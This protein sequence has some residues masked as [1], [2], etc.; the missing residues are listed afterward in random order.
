MRR[1]FLNGPQL[2]PELES[3]NS[4]SPQSA[5]AP[6]KAHIL[7][8][9][10]ASFKLDRGLKSENFPDSSNKPASGLIPAMLPLVV[11]QLDLKDP[12]DITTLLAIQR[13]S[14]YGWSTVT[15]I[16]YR[17]VEVRDWQKFLCLPD[18][19]QPFTEHPLLFKHESIGRL[20]SAQIRSFKRRYDAFS[21][22]KT[23]VL[24]T[25]P[26]FPQTL[27]FFKGG[28]WRQADK[29]TI[30]FSEDHLMMPNLVEMDV[31][32]TAWIPFNILAGY[33]NAEEMMHKVQAERP[34]LDLSMPRLP[35]LGAIA[36]PKILHITA[37]A[38]STL[39][40]GTATAEPSRLLLEGQFSSFIGSHDRSQIH[41]HDMTPRLLMASSVNRCDPASVHV[42]M[43]TRPFTPPNQ[44]ENALEFV[45]IF[46]NLLLGRLSVWAQATA[47]IFQ[48]LGQHRKQPKESLK[49]Q[50]RITGGDNGLVYE[51]KN[52][53]QIIQL[54]IKRLCRQLVM[55]GLEY[56]IVRLADL[57]E[58]VAKSYEGVV[59]KYVGKRV[60]IGQMLFDPP[61]KSE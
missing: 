53:T 17:H 24:H 20:D 32:A 23:I 28:W 59:A 21:Y 36:A 61:A 5:T 11:A 13:S 58:Q 8:S 16:I 14:S 15:P 56:E 18:G 38:H 3:Q 34:D 33:Y 7:A 46:L 41:L 19:I 60:Y 6:D 48:Q 29:A 57:D 49:C 52:P 39:Q 10:D 45:S 4:G 50:W 35:L 43:T 25:F 30:G 37:P 12:H 27:V 54:I 22:T 9:S 47:P 40:G 51:R 1:G 42:I 31:R 26:T 44:G 55:R 2:K